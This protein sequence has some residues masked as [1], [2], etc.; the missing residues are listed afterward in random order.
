M[1]TISEDPTADEFT[2]LTQ[3]LDLQRAILR[4]KCAGLDA[5]AMAATPTASTMHLAGLLKHLTV[6]EEGWF[7][8]H[9]AGQ[10]H[11]EPWASVDWAADPDW[12]WR[13]A[14]DDD[15]DE[16]LATHAVACD[17]SRS[18]VAA[19][20]SLDQRAVGESHR[21]PVTLRWILVHMI[22]EYARHNGHADLI[23]EGIDG[24][25]GYLPPEHPLAHD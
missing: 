14:A 22:E 20:S 15:P 8:H 16:L 6:V 12:E 1:A 13:T 10:D 7:A 2:T 24:A 17:R 25:V 5:D 9:F 3:S 4:W 18:V 19:A 21:G 11:S 23:R